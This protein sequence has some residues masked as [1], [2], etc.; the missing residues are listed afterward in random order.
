MDEKPIFSRSHAYTLFSSLILQGISQS[1]LPIVQQLDDLAAVLPQPVDLVKAAAMHQH[2]LGMNIFANESFFL[3][4]AGLVGGQVVDGVLASYQGVGYIPPA[5]TS[6][7]HL[8]VEL[9][10]LSYL[11][12]AQ[13]DALADGYH[14]VAQEMQVAQRQFLQRHLLCWMAPCLTAIRRADNAFYSEVASL[15]LALVA[16]HWAQ[17]SAG[18]PTKAGAEILLTAAPSLLGNDKTSLRDIAEFLVTPVYAGIYLSR[19]AITSLGRQQQLPRGFGER[20]LLL[21]NLL[22][23]AAQYDLAVAVFQQIGGIVDAW[24]TAYAAMMAEYPLL[25]PFVLPWQQRAQQTQE[26]LRQMTE[27]IP[28]SNE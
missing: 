5:S 6:A 2:V 13:A 17:V 3:D 15:L 23:S 21:T 24:V 18:V 4:A 11:C 28:L 1:T 19:D 22:Q 9:S 7:D 16:D 20:R 27:L 12:G 8:G 14:T 25:T 26:Q 10:L